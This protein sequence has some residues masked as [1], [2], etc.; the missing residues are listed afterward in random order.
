MKKVV[1]R[2]RNKGYYRVLHVPIWLWVF[3]ILPGHLAYAL[4]TG[5]PDTRH[6][7]WL[8]VVTAVCAWRGWLG[9]LPGVERRPYITHYGKHQPNLWYRVVCYTAA[10]I[11]LLVPFTLN[12]IGMAIAAVTGE[13]LLGRLFETLYYPLALAVVLATVFDMTPRA[14]RSTR[15]EGAERA[16][17]YVAIW[18]VVPA[19][20]VAWGAWRL[21]SQYGGDPLA[22]A[23]LRLAVFVV[24]AVTFFTLGYKEIL[25]RT[26]R[27]H[28]ESR[29][30]RG[31][32]KRKGLPGPVS[33]W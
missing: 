6:W 27:L 26:E 22:L 25:P 1:D 15:D 9:R 12:A 14:R 7:I 3:W 31:G 5:G 32:R 4:F 17:F 18:T 21:I 28:V 19:Q 8:A 23:R 24:V 2:K 13:W 29:R 11:D 30:Q 10:W 16:W 20:V 33:P